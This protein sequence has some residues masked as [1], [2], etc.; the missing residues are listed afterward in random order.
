MTGF[1]KGWKERDRESKKGCWYDKGNIKKFTWIYIYR[2][3]C[4]PPCCDRKMFSFSFFVTFFFFECFN[5]PLIKFYCLNF[6]LTLRRTTT[7]TT[8]ILSNT[9]TTS[10]P[11]P[12][13]RRIVNTRRDARS[14]FK[15]IIFSFDFV[16]EE[17]QQ[18]Q[19]NNIIDRLSSL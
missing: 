11:T 2:V 18:K 14:I 6:D 16:D 5:L 4:K 12:R 19:Q 15:V 17:K 9:T 7:T 1:D 3:T 13:L 10:N 8:E